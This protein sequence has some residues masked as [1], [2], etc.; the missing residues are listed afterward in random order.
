MILTIPKRYRILSLP[1]C[2]THSY[3]L[4]RLVFFTCFDK[5]PHDD[6]IT[7]NPGHS[8]SNWEGL[9]VRRRDWLLM[10]GIRVL[11]GPL[12]SVSDDRGQQLKLDIGSFG[13]CF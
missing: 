3:S 4:H 13:S 7:I 5:K 6:D 11:V 10:M 9:L 1:L 12:L 8:K 2:S